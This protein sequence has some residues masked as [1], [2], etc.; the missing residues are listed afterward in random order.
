MDG[1]IDRQMDRWKYIYMYICISIL[2]MLS[3]YGLWNVLSGNSK[4]T[5]NHKLK[6]SAL[7]FCNVRVQSNIKI[8]C[9]KAIFSR[10]LSKH[11]LNPHTRNKMPHNYETIFFPVT[12]LI[13]GE[14]KKEKKS[15]KKPPQK[16]LQKSTNPPISPAILHYFSIKAKFPYYLW[17]SD[18]HFPKTSTC[19]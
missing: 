19:K 6:Q 1:W 9:L 14:K 5:T 8:Y 4:L 13:L 7:G 11:T 16:P 3:I 2:L 15:T 10:Q 12:I 17:I 18:Q